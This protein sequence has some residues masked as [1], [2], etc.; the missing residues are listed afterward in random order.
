MKGRHYVDRDVILQTQAAET[1]LFLFLMH[2]LIAAGRDPVLP[3]C[4]FEPSTV[5]DY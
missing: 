3:L 2:Q 4:M 5:Y 1:P